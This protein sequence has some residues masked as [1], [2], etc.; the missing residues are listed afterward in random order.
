VAIK[1]FSIDEKTYKEYSNH[2]KKEGISMS[3]KIDNFIKSE[4]DNLKK[5]HKQISPKPIGSESSSDPESKEY[6]SFSKY[7]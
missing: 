1:T 3:K 4:L 5:K 6:N 2:C 7:C